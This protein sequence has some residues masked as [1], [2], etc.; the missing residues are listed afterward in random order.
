MWNAIC[1]VVVG[2]E[3]ATNFGLQWWVY[4]ILVLLGAVILFFLWLAGRGS[5]KKTIS[6][7]FWAFKDKHPW[8]AAI[9]L[10]TVA[11]FFGYLLIVHLWFKWYFLKLVFK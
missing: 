7:E 9:C 5:K 10:A 1:L 8:K 4:P 11:W 3:I 2:V 6:K